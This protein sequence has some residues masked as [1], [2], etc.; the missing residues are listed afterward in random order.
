[1]NALTQYIEKLKINNG[2]VYDPVRSKWLQALPEE[3][4]RQT[5]LY[6]LM[7]D[8]QVP[9]SKIAVEHQII[10]L[11]KIHR[12]DIIIMN[13]SYQPCMIFEIKAH[14]EPLNANVYAQLS[15]YSYISTATLFCM[16]NGITSLYFELQ[17]QQWQAIS[18][19]TIK[20]KCMK[21]IV[22]K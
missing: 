7:H 17:N 21:L 19:E 5:V 13:A 2:K 8:W 12:C 11:Q 14:T 20:E 3:L 1:L 22:D 16:S 15:R 9:K 18:L 10:H 4:I 6:C